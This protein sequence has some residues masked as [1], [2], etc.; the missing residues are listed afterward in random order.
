MAPGS[1]QGKIIKM[2]LIL[3]LLYKPN[4]FSEAQTVEEVGL[5][6]NHQMI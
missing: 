6:T 2:N 3:S 1:D 5:R 4:L